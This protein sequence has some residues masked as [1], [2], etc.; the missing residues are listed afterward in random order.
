MSPF[1]EYKYLFYAGLVI[2]L[3]YPLYL[4]TAFKGNILWQ[5][6]WVFKEYQIIKI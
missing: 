5:A 6:K 2:Q 4:L 1:Y 3:F